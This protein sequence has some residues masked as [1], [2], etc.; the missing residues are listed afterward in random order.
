[1]PACHL[2]AV[3]HVLHDVLPNEPWDP[4]FLGQRLMTIY[5]DTASFRL[6]KARAKGERYVTLRVRCYR[7]ADGDELYAVSAKTEAEKFRTEISP[8]EANDIHG[9]PPT[10]GTA[11]LD[12]LPAHLLA[13]V[14]ELA[15][16]E[17]LVPVVAIYCIR[18][19]V[20]DTVDRFTLDVEVGTDTGK[21]L[22]YAVLEFKSMDA[23]ARPPA[24]LELIGLRPIKLSKFLW[25]SCP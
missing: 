3:A 22:P 1:V 17:P 6:R 5:F 9:W 18:Y 24:P 10:C 13:R 15:G 23:K 21:R 2:P 4:H 8:E 25:A 7:G 19:A 12:H 11:P 14:Q 16:D 20:Q